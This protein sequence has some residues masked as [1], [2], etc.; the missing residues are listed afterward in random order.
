MI[1]NRRGAKAL[2]KIADAEER[3]ARAEEKIFRALSDELKLPKR[4]AGSTGE[5]PILSGKAKQKE[6][7]KK[8]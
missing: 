1:T 4:S 2:E 7:S 3:I 5:P 8:T 6:N